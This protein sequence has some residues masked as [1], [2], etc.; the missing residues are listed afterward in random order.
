LARYDLKAPQEYFLTQANK[1]LARQNV[2]RSI[3]DE[4]SPVVDSSEGP[5][6]VSD[7]GKITGGL[8]K[9][10][11]VYQLIALASGYRERPK[12]KRCARCKE[13]GHIRDYCPKIECREC[14]RL[15]HSD[16]ICPILGGPNMHRLIQHIN[17]QSRKMAAEI[18][19][20][21]LEKEKDSSHT[22]G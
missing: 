1:S 13:K 21:L 18:A 5:G 4:V 19:G 16:N 9:D 8:T 10:G 6:V 12:V 22:L 11:E 15:G 2:A 14:G 7:D 3:Q 17:R 20:R